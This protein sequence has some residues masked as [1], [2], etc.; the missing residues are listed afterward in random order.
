MKTGIFTG[1]F[2]QSQ[3]KTGSGVVADDEDHD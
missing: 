3:Q 2:G 1:W